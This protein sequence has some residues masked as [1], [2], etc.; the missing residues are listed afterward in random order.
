MPVSGALLPLSARLRARDVLD[1][2]STRDDL[3]FTHTLDVPVLLYHLER[4][5]YAARFDRVGVEALDA[6]LAL[7]VRF[8]FVPSEAIWD[9]HPEWA[10]YV[11]ERSHLVYRDSGFSIYRVD[12]AG[13]P[14][15]EPWTNPHRRSVGGGA[16]VPDLLRGDPYFHGGRLVRARFE[17][18]PRISALGMK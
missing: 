14:R 5:G 11:E 3:V 2:L 12:A 4:Y 17:D 16:H 10:V 15:E 13:S 18:A 7:G 6:Y 1:E 9:E 8:I